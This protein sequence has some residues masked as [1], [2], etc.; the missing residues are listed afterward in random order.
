MLYRNRNRKLICHLWIL[1]TL[2]LIGP[3]GWKRIDVFNIAENHMIYFFFWKK[4]TLNIRTVQ[5]VDQIL[6][7]CKFWTFKNFFTVKTFLKQKTRTCHVVGT[8]IPL[9]WYQIGTVPTTTES[10]KNGARTFL[11]WSVV[12]GKMRKSSVHVLN[13]IANTVLSKCWIIIP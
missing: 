5:C 7:D 10:S 4:L 8:S 11:G 1:K 9:Q 12:N 2:N 6:L 3:I 13:N